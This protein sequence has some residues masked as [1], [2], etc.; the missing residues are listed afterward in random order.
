VPDDYPYDDPQRPEE[1][2]QAG[3]AEETSQQPV[4]PLSGPHADPYG[5]GSTRFG[6]AAHVVA[7]LSY[8]FWP[9]LPLIIY[10][11]ET[12]N[13]FVRF[14]ALQSLILGLGMLVVAI[15]AFVLRF[16]PLFGALA[17]MALWIGFAAL[18]IWGI[19]SAF[20]GQWKRLPVVGEMAAQQLRLDG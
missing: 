14:H 1:P 5:L 2:E 18:V 15:A 12:E 6:L 4:S 19:V 16:V 10:L 7:G 8:F 17:S 20:T 13:R 3:E 11:L 9:V